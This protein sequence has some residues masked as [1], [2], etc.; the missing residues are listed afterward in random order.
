MLLLLLSCLSTAPDADRDGYAEAEDC[1]DLDAETYPG[2]PET[3][4]GQDD[5]CDGR[6]DEGVTGTWYADLD[7]DGHGDPASALEGCER[8]LNYRLAGDD[9]DDGDAGVYPGAPEA[10]DALDQDCDGEVDEGAEGLW[11]EDNDGDGYG[12]DPIRACEPP[13]GAVAE[14]GDC[15]DIDA[16]AHPGAP[17]RCNRYDDD[18]DGLIDEGAGEAWVDA[19][20]DGH[21]DPDQP[22]VSCEREGGVADN[23]DDCDDSDASVW[24]GA[25]EDCDGV[26]NDCDDAV[27]EDVKQGWMLV[28]VDQGG[29]PYEIDPATGRLSYMPTLSPRPNQVTSFDVREDGLAV[30]M[31]LDRGP[32]LVELDLCAASATWLGE[33]DSG[34]V[35]G[36]GFGPNGDLFALDY[37]ADQLLTLD[38]ADGATLDAVDLGFD[39]GT[40]GIAWSC[41]DRVFYGVDGNADTLFTLDPATG[42]IGDVRALGV[43]FTYVG[44]E[45]EPSS[46]TLL[47][48]TG[49]ALY[50]IEP[51]TATAS[52]IANLSLAG[53]NDLALYPECP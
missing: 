2:A 12:G 44:I 4:D 5:D 43:D 29:T 8:P 30:A 13:E 41:A 18:C 28:T 11:Y 23:P 40:T 49:S 10:C 32:R 20:Q 26:D 35:G 51:S 42:Q 34:S 53:V 21:G 45:Y 3:C 1:D 17:E 7:Q 52:W 46:G 38:P 39:L 25:P 22:L 47:A 14:G 24:P 27:D 9:C 37:D 48:S 15:R 6:T 19:D 31:D 33:V 16:Q 36:I 50:R